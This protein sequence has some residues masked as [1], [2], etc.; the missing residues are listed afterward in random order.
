MPASTKMAGD[1]SY[2]TLRR[3]PGRGRTKSSRLRPSR[4]RT[5]GRRVGLVAAGLRVAGA[6]E[7][8]SVAVPI[9]EDV[10]R[11]GTRFGRRRQA[12]RERR[13]TRPTGRRAGAGSRLRRRHIA[14]ASAP[15]NLRRRALLPERDLALVARVDGRRVRAR[16]WGRRGRRAIE[17]RHRIARPQLA[18]AGAFEGLHV[19]LAIG[20]RPEGTRQARHAAREAGSDR[21]ARSAPWIDRGPG[22]CG[23]TAIERDLVVADEIVAR[24]A[25]AARASVALGALRADDRHAAAAPGDGEDR[26]QEKAENPREVGIGSLTVRNDRATQESSIL[27]ANGCHDCAEPCRPWHA[28]RAARPGGRAHHAAARA[29][30]TRS[31]SSVPSVG[32]I[33]RLRVRSPISSATGSAPRGRASSPAR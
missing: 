33:G 28:R 32:Y 11:T 1:A 17:N 6:R 16:G 4:L 31:C 8:R 2:V 15:R 5:E 21:V 13:L 27:A 22:I 12:G 18:L 29:S 9:G 20:D 10:V 19:P 3:R 7:T 14:A 23:R 25:G 30:T 26:E 24:I